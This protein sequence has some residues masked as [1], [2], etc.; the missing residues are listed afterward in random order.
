VTQSL[1]VGAG[2]GVAV[3][4]LVA[5]ELVVAGARAAGVEA[6]PLMAAT[7]TTARIVRFKVTP[8]KLMRQD[9]KGK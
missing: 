1:F 5:G 2:V 4:F 9:M 6:H 7:Q 3:A 8:I